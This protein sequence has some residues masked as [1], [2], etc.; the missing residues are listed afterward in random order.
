MRK[1]LYQNIELLTGVEHTQIGPLKGSSIGNLKSISN[2]WLTTIDGKISDFGKM[3]C[4]PNDANEIID[5]TNHTILPTYC[6]SHTHLVYAATREDEFVDRINGLSYQEL[7]ARGGGILNSAKKIANASKANLIESTLVRL[8]EIIRWG[9]GAVEIKSGYGLDVSNEIKMLEVIFEVSKISPISIQPTLLAAHAVPLEFKNDKKS[10]I[11]TITNELIPEVAKRN[12]AVYCDVFCEENYFTPDETV[13][14][15]ECGKKYGLIPKVHANQLAQSGGVQA[16]IKVGARS[17]DHLE[18]L[19][20]DELNLL[21]NSNSI[22][23]ILPGA[24]FF[25]N[26][27]FPP[28]KKIIEHNISLAIASDYNPGSSPSGNMNFMLSLACVNYKLTPETAI[29]A[30]TINGA[31][32]MDLEKTHGSIDKGKTANFIIA[33]KNTGYRFIPYSFANDCID[34][35]II[36]GEKFNGIVYP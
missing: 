10:Y 29:N 19:F 28:A 2:A 35:I 14:I 17:V 30:A 7:A 34:S 18:Y 24:Q 23:T 12:L 4:C 9:T 26:L 3:D 33:K 20:D 32:A 36:N 6:D 16:G 21:S 25:L 11:H 13:L 5:C 1:R 15:L 22:A 31:F 27:P 8:N